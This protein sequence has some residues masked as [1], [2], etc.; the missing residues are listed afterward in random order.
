[1]IRVIWRREDSR[2]AED[3]VLLFVA[4]ETGPDFRHLCVV[5]HAHDAHPVGTGSHDGAVFRVQ[6]FVGVE[7]E[8]AAFDDLVG[9]ELW[10]LWGEEGKTG[11][12]D[13]VVGFIVGGD[14]CPEWTGDVGEWVE[15]TYPVEDDEEAVDDECGGGDENETEGVEEE[16]FEVGVEL[17]G[18]GEDFG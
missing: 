16:G 18:Y 12:T 10:G 15:G 5:V 1:M 3:K 2:D 11:R 17:V 4:V 6:D 13:I 7:G 14:F 8:D 9:L